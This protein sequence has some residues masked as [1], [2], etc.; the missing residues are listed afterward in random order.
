M[1][2]K[3]K[4]WHDTNTFLVSNITDYMR[5][6]LCKKVQYYNIKRFFKV[7]VS[8]IIFECINGTQ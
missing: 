8:T 3:H 5:Y 4:D 2:T 1:I 6:N 7:I